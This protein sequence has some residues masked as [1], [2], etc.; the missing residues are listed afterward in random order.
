MDK[1]VAGIAEH[2]KIENEDKVVLSKRESTTHKKHFDME[3]FFTITD[4]DTGEVLLDKTNAIHYENMS[5]IIA[6]ALT[7]QMSSNVQT[8]IIAFMAL[9][10]GGCVVNSTGDITYMP[11]NTTGTTAQLYNQ[12]YNIINSN[13]S[14]GFQST[15]YHIPGKT[16]SDIIMTST[17]GYDQ[18]PTQD[19][20]DNTTTLGDFVF[21]EIGLYSINNLLLTHCTFAPI[22]KSLNRQ[23]TITYTLRISLV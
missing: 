4:A 20:F 18:P 16:Y 11:P 3:G 7:G 6:L 10:N 12:T 13:S 2:L 21:N 14:I 23:I 22:Q 15:V 9:G 19:A 5:Y 8:G 17:L 1:L